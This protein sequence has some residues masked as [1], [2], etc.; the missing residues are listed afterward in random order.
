MSQNYP[1]SGAERQ[2]SL[3]NINKEEKGDPVTYTCFGL[4]GQ[5]L[6]FPCLRLMPISL[7]LDKCGS[8]HNLTFASDSNPLFPASSLL[9][10]EPFVSHGVSN[11]SLS[12]GSFIVL[13]T[14]LFITFIEFWTRKSSI[15]IVQFKFSFQEFSD[16]INFFNVILDLILYY[17]RRFQT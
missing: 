15:R 4:N 3:P 13:I 6:L 9:L 11:T 10:H 5:N 16:G 2:K 7:Q 1:F 12:K 17:I 8:T 14:P